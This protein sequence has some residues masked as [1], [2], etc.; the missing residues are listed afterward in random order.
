MLRRIE[1]KGELFKPVL[2]SGQTLDK[3]AAL[4]EEMTAKPGKRPRRRA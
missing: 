1:R 4:L 3:P 2:K